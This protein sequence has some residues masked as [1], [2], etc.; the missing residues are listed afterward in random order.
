VSQI[1]VK[2][3]CKSFA[4]QQVLRGVDL[5]VEKGEVV[6]LIGPSGSGKSTLLRCMNLLE[7]P[8]SGELWW[9][10]ERIDYSA[11]SEEILS[12]HRARLGMVFQHF[13]LFPHLSVLS[14]VMEGPRRVLGLPKDEAAS[15]ASA[16]LARVGLASKESAYPSQLSGGQKQRVAIARSLAMEPAAL[17]LDEVTSALD[18]EMVAGINDLLGELAE[19]MTMVAVTHDLS[20]AA[21]VSSR[22]G[23]MDDGQL[24][25]SGSPDQVFRDPTTDR[26]RE[27]LKAVSGG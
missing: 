22:V 5:A 21:R 14:N 4:N 13:H 10:D 23:F 3:L 19:S 8:D 27:F 24:L 20:F 12:R 9:E 16:L 7:T 6:T 2:D 26:A 25:E 11:S 1:A 17:L 18:V 15:R